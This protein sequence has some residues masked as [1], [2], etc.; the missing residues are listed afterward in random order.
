MPK[1][2]LELGP[3]PKALGVRQGTREYSKGGSGRPF[4]SFDGCVEIMGWMYRVGVG[5]NG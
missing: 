1:S 4:R 2:R 3:E 5:G